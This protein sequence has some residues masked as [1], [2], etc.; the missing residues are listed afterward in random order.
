MSLTEPNALADLHSECLDFSGAHSGDNT[1]VAPVSLQIVRSL[2]LGYVSNIEKSP[3]ADGR[4][5][6]VSLACC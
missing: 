4:G 6:G 5:A 2:Y 3:V 1:V